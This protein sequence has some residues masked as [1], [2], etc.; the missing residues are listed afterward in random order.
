VTVTR[1][2]EATPS[3]V[4]TRKSLAI[5]GFVISPVCIVHVLAGCTTYNIVSRV[6]SENKVEDFTKASLKIN[7]HRLS[8]HKQFTLFLL[9]I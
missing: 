8:L 4:K 9:N 3:A 6:K 1:C 5:Y 2:H 7:D